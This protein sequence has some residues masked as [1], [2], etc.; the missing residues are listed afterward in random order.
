LGKFIWAHDSIFSSANVQ[1]NMVSSFKQKIECLVSAQTSFVNEA[2]VTFD[3]NLRDIRD[4]MESVFALI[5]NRTDELFHD[6]KFN[7]KLFNAH[8]YL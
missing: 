3:K 7:G 2:K 5:N 8:R 1:E 6:K 4:D